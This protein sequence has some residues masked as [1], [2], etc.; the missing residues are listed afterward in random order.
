MNYKAQ[1]RPN[2]PNH[3]SLRGFRAAGVG[4]LLSAAAVLADE[5]PGVQD[6]A[7]PAAA[8]VPAAQEA[9]AAP[10]LPSAEDVLNQARTRLEGLDSLTCELQQTASMAGIRLVAKGTYTEA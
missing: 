10:A 1:N 8:A 9:A 7:A 3:L 4:L 5:K 2:L 6:P